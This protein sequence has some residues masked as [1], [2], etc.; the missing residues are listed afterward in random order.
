MCVCVC[1]CLCVCVCVFTEN[2][3]LRR[4]LVEEGVI[5]PVITLLKS[6]KLMLRKNGANAIRSLAQDTDNQVGPAV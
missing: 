5:E 6:Q 4:P 2:P 1:V 3:V